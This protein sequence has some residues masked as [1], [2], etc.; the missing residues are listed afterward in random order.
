[1][2]AIRRFNPSPVKA[3]QGDEVVHHIGLNGKGWKSQKAGEGHFKTFRLIQERDRINPLGR[4]PKIPELPEETADQPG[5]EQTIETSRVS[6]LQVFQQG[7]PAHS[8]VEGFQEENKTDPDERETVT[9]EKDGGGKAEDTQN[10][11]QDLSPGRNGPPFYRR[12]FKETRCCQKLGRLKQSGEDGSIG[13]GVSEPS[14]K[15]GVGK[16]DVVPVFQEKIGGLKNEPDKDGPGNHQEE[17][18]DPA[19]YER[20]AFYP[21]D[22]SVNGQD[23]GPPGET[24]KP[25]VKRFNFSEEKEFG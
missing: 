16:V 12:V 3:E 20:V 2:E 24:I 10:D 18:L 5:D 7:R 8:V 25:A 19:G 4:R 22:H 11:K 1:M 17:F 21:V 13:N 14:F 23:I 6:L 9:G 15:G